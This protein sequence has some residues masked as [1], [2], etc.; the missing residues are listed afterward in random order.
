MRAPEPVFLDRDGVL[1]ENVP[2]YVKTE[3]QWV[4]LPGALEAAA[5]LSLS[6]HPVV[7]VTNQSA[8]G[9]G[10]MTLEA[11]E[12]INGLLE[13]RVTSLGGRIDAVLFCP[14]APSEN[15]RCRKPATGM[16][17]DARAGLSLPEGGW[18]VGDAWSDMMMGTAAGL[19]TIMVMTGRGAS[20]MASGRPSGC[21][22]P[23]FVADDLNEAA[24]IILRSDG[25][26]PGARCAKA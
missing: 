16:V 22:R 9:R 23:D 14:H 3:S 20:Q 25:G 18:L 6:G 24:R 17:E 8:V 15:C 21:S 10:L 7:V 13:R 2:D 26:L 4:P 12:R 19:R 11:V 1:N 5:V